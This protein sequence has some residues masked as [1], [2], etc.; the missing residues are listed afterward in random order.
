[1]K[2]LLCFFILSST[3]F[4]KPLVVGSKKFTESVIL[5]EILRLNLSHDAIEAEHSREL[6]GTALLWNALLNGDVD[7]YV[8]YSGTIQEEILKSGPLAEEKMR[9]LLSEKGIGMSKPLGFNNTYAIGMSEVKAQKLG[10][11]KISDLRLHSKLRFGWAEEFM[12]RKDGWPGLKR[13]YQFSHENVRGIDHDVAYRALVSDDID[14]MDLYSTDAEIPYYELR[15]LK[16]DKFYFPRYEAILLYRLDKK[17]QLVPLLVRLQ[18]SISEKEMAEM[19]RLVKIEK[20]G[21]TVVA[22]DFIKRKMNLDIDYKLVT[23]KDRVFKRSLEHLKLVA[24]SLFLAVLIAIPLGVVA[25]KTK[26][27]GQLILMVVSTVQTVPALALLV[28]LIRP[29]H[30]LGLPGIGDVPALIA[31]FLYSLLP[32]VRNTHAGL[33]QI[34]KH[35][36]ETASVLNLSNTTRLWKIELPLALPLI[37]AGIKT[38]LVLNIGFAT[39]GALVGAGGYGQSILTG[40]RLDDYQFIFEGA[41]PAAILALFAQK[42]FDLIEKRIISRG[43]RS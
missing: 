4:A 42:V 18:N 10:I 5:G 30:L 24:I 23:W 39:L 34:P 40:I 2:F 13:I 15:T 26:F 7:L 1:M 28:L 14:V 43:L 41:F 27:T 3:A 36:Q 32:I 22:A 8:E 19:N 35:L 6:G 37:L 33:T 11:E 38:S 20:K 9:K 29:L 25:A 12:E 31:L 17:E 21:S 16:D